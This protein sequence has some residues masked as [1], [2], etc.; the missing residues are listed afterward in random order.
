MHGLHLHIHEAS[1]PKDEHLPSLTRLKGC[2][3]EKG[4]ELHLQQHHTI[5][6]PEIFYTCYFDSHHPHVDSDPKI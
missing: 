1:T 3:L 4:L 6:L 5:E 2:F